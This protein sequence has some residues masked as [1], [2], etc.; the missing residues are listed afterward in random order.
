[1]KPYGLKNYQQQSAYW[2]KM[3]QQNPAA[4]GNALMMLKPQTATVLRLHYA[5]GKTLN[6]IGNLIGKSNSTVRNHHN[7]GIFLVFQY[8]EYQQAP[9]SV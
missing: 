4:L 1:M 5:E 6:E 8:L 9:P 2:R 3:Q 7:R